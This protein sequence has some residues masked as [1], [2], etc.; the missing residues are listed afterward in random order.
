[1]WENDADEIGR[2]NQLAL[3]DQPCLTEPRT[4]QRS[5]ASE[6]G[7]EIGAAAAF[8]HHD[9][10]DNKTARLVIQLCRRGSGRQ[11][12]SDNERVLDG[13]TEKVAV[14]YFD[15]PVFGFDRVIK[16]LDAGIPRIGNDDR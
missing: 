10:Q 2:F 15:P 8:A 5:A 12:G 16:S 11:F 6:M 7:I 9:V 14:S 3:A 1:M 13:K 4:A